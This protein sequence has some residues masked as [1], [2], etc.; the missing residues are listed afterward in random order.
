MRCTTHSTPLIIRAAH[1]KQCPDGSE[2]AMQTPKLLHLL[3]V[4][5]LALHGFEARNSPFFTIVPQYSRGVTVRDLAIRAPASP[6]DWNG[7]SA[8]EWPSHNT[9]GVNVESCDDVL[10]ER[11]FIDNGDDCVA[12]YSGSNEQ[13]L[14]RASALLLLILAYLSLVPMLQLAY[15]IVPYLICFAKNDGRIN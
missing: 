9:D 6:E 1:A 13:G 11:L 2:Q 7:H 8:E 14:C 3:H 15:Y 10:V 4:D 12:I 5:G